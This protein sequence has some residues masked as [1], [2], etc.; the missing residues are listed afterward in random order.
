M[1]ISEGFGKIKSSFLE[2]LFPLMEKEK[3]GMAVFG[4]DLFSESDLQLI[5]FNKSFTKITGYNLEDLFGVSSKYF[6]EKIFQDK[7]EFSLDEILVNFFLKKQF[8]TK[9]GKSCWAKLSWSPVM[10][11]SGRLVHLVLRI[12]D[13]TD[14]EDARKEKERSYHETRYLALHDS[15]TGLLNRN[16]AGEYW[17]SLCTNRRK[18]HKIDMATVMM[19][20]VDRFKEIN[21][22]YGHVSG[23][24][25]LEAISKII[26]KIVRFEEVFRWGG[27]EFLIIMANADQEVAELKKD[28]IKTAIEAYVF[29]SE[30]LKNVV[31]SVSIGY[32]VKKNLF[33]GQPLGDAVDLADASMYCD[34]KVGHTVDL[35]VD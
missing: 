28:Q 35:T 12:S 3:C 24:I 27:D 21:D 8:L 7:E 5:S 19:I 25:C 9:E 17:N 26:T 10:N 4:L 29:K 2:L 23:D 31:L 33:Q 30:K 1:A 13:I 6:R 34:K 14:E 15:L 11:D 16:A 22:T 32:T 18:D 20:D